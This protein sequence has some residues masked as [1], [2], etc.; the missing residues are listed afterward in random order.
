MKWACLKNLDLC[1]PKA[2]ALG[3]AYKNL[4]F[5]FKGGSLTLTLKVVSFAVRL[6]QKEWLK[7][8]RALLSI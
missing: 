4:F 6:W 7:E 5:I 1:L 8:R 3:E 2:S